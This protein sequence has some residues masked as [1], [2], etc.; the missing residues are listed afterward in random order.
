MVVESRQL[1]LRWVNGLIYSLRYGEKLLV[2][3]AINGAITHNHTIPADER[4]TP[5]VLFQL[6]TLADRLEFNLAWNS[7]SRIRGIGGMTG[8]C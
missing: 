3:D 8:R 1:S 4:L 6:C 5:D 7:T 2:W